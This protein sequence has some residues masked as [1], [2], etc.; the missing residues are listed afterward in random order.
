MSLQ[1]EG[2]RRGRSRS[3]GGR[4]RD[5]SRSRG[6]TLVIDVNP[7]YSDRD[8]ERE[9]YFEYEERRSSYKS[10]T[11]PSDDYYRRPRSPAVENG[12][13]TTYGDLREHRRDGPWDRNS[14]PD[15]EREKAKTGLGLMDAFLPQKYAK[16]LE[17]SDAYNFMTAPISDRS[18][19]RSQDRRAEKKEKLEEDLAYGKLP[20][21]SVKDGRPSSPHPLSPLTI[22]PTYEYASMPQFPYASLEKRDD[23]YGHP[24]EPRHS[25]DRLDVGD[26]RHGRGR[27]RSKSPAPR[28]HSRDNRERKHSHRDSLTAD[29]R[30]STASVAAPDAGDGSGPRKSALKRTSSPQPPANRMSSLSVNTAYNAGSL[31]AAPPSPL[32]ESYHGTYQSMS[33]MPSPLLIPTQFGGDAH[34]LDVAPL[35]SDDERGGGAGE[36]KRGR[37]ARFADPE[38]DAQQLADAL[39]GKGPPKTEPLVEILPG[40]THE[41]VMELRTEYKRRVK[42]GP[43]KKG[44]N[45][46][47]HIRVRLKDAD[48]SLMKACYA[49]ALGRWESEAYWSSF[50][51]QGDKTRR[52]L[53]IES[54]MGRTNEEVRRIKESFN[55]KTYDNSLTRCMRHELKEDKFKK[56]VLAVLDEQRMEDVDRYGRQLPIDR[57][58]VKDDVY[59]LHKAVKTEKGGE[60]AMISIV[61]SRSD[62]HLREI[63]RAYNEEYGSNFARVALRKSGNLVV[64][65]YPSLRKGNGLD[66]NLSQGELLAHILNGVINK[67]VRDALLVHHALTASKKDALRRELLTSRL[68]RYH[69]DGNHM[70]AVKKAYHERYGKDM[71]EAVE[72][73]TSGEWGQ[74]CRE[75]CITRMP[76]RVEKFHVSR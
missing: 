51:Y 74:F 65:N 53:L 40:L 72:D 2:H 61:V 28:H 6:P 76:D 12:A 54:L 46:A 68:V 1:V 47:K 36:K 35:D 70:V 14:D 39:R 50:W 43:E 38:D 15:R 11:S 57:N 45:V 32:L 64:R 48:P 37:R 25:S 9:R 55:D 17:E 75:L 71:M 3:P 34:V 8:R 4:E 62:N 67:P 31:S 7:D 33:P 60:S 18:R 66:V 26:S 42:T 13:R 5:R 69:W 29:P 44:V 19:E 63:L 73:G 27:N 49:T 23:R 22:S 59:D 52:E 21:P 56:A 41:Q 58:L 16:K 30:G 10:P 24:A 20:A